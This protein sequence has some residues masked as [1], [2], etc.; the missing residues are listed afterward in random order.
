MCPCALDW[1]NDLPTEYYEQAELELEVEKVMKK[2]E[3]NGEKQEK[4]A[5]ESQPTG[6]AV[7]ES[8]EDNIQ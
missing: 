7:E 2:A 4:P 5:D 8:V 6:T 3:E 1:L